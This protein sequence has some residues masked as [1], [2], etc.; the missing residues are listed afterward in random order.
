MEQL[1]KIF[2]I[3]GAI[4]F[5]AG[6]V[7]FVLAK[8]RFRGLPGDVVYRG[9]HTTVYFPIVT[10]VVVSIVGTMLLWLWRWFSRR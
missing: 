1:A 8:L 7:L 5:S 6:G 2:L 4:L 10:C 3:A 9:E